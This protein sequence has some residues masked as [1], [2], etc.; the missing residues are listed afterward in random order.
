VVAAIDKIPNFRSLL[1]ALFVKA[2]HPVMFSSR[3]PDTLKGLIDELGPLARAG[4]V[5]EAVEF[6]DVVMVVVPYTA[7]EQIGKDYGNALAKK[8]LVI[9]VSNPIARRD[10]AA[11]VEWVDE[12][13]GAGLATAKLLPGAHIVRVFNAIN[14]AKLSADAHANSSA[15]RSPATTRTLLASRRPS[16]GR[17][18]STLLSSADWQWANIPIRPRTHS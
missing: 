7:L 5:A 9:D 14:Y 1:G 8:V 2:G 11:I 13:G 16:S 10:G 6:G 15:F 18:V 17:L 4:T 12:Q 3:H